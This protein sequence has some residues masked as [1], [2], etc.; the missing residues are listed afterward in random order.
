[1]VSHPPRPDPFPVW[2]VDKQKIASNE[3]REEKEIEPDDNHR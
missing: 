1:L 3:S 2:N